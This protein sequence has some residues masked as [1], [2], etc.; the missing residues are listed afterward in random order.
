MRIRLGRGVM[1]I[2]LVPQ[3]IDVDWFDSLRVGMDAAAA[4]IGDSH[5]ALSDHER[6]AVK[7][8]S[9]ELSRAMKR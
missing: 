7:D 4:D 5:H 8:F 9:K 2:D 6:E 1:Q 3:E